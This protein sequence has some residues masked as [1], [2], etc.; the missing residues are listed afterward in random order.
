METINNESCLINRPGGFVITDRALSFCSF[1]MNSKILDLGCGSG[2]TVNHIIQNYNLEA[3]G[4]DKYLNRYN[5]N[6]IKATAE[7]IPFSD[8]SFEGV[9]ME[10]SFSVVDNQEMVLKE[11]CRVLKTNGYL[12]ISD[13]YAR[14]EAAHLNGCLG[15]VDTKE[16]IIN[17]LE[18]NGFTINLF[19]DFSTHLQA[20]WGQIIFDKGAKSFYCEMGVNPDAMKR[21]KCGYY[22]IVA[23][24]NKQQI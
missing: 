7:K 16:V 8:A 23:R 24:K 11:C 14:G 21:I 5:P 17:I 19:E 18:N 6:I 22:L 10:C 20:M 1:Q 15:R 2:A 13:M 3:F 4:L 9:L 12:I